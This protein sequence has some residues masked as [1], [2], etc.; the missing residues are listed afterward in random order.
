MKVSYILARDRWSS[1]LLQLS[2]LKP[3][4]CRTIPVQKRKVANQKTGAIL[5]DKSNDFIW[6]LQLG[7]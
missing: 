3:Q 6:H 2:L 7:S 1:F 5:T 4:S